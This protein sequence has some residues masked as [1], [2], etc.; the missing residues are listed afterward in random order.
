MSNNL[1]RYAGV[2]NGSTT[3]T[4]NN[5]VVSPLNNKAYS[6]VVDN[7]SGGLDPSLE[8][9]NNWLLLN[10]SLF[11]T[12]TETTGMN[13][14]VTLTIPNLTDTGTVSICYVHAGLGGGPQYLKT[15]TNTAN[16]CL[17]T[18]NTPVDTNDQIIWQV[19]SLS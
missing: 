5:M 2:W 1:L 15:I 4:Y 10:P 18:F 3:Y 9:L 17:L 14:Q 19:L 13:T 7:W 8:I 12:Y 16:T 11:G 6:L